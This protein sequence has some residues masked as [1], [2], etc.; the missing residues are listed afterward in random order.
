MSFFRENLF[1]IPILSWIMAVLIK[2]VYF[3][4]KGKF[5]VSS[6]LGSGGMPSV[7]SALVTSLT[8]AIGIKYG[9][10]SDLFI[11]CLVFSTIIIYD[12]I[13]VRF[14]A[15]LHARALNNL[16]CSKEQSTEYTFNESI[17]H[18]PEEAF[19]G[20][21]VGILTAVIFMSF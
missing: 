8:T 1:L 6:A 5:S 9:V 11:T 14:E 18:L 2:G 4:Y 7:H 16:R 12:A 20:S 15:G 3:A 10:F 17:G 13:N 19:V 21:V